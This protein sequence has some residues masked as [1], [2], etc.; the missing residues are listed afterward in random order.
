MS[1]KTMDHSCGDEKL[2]ALTCCSCN[3]DLKRIK[4]LVNKPK[5]ICKS[6]GRVANKKTNLCQPKP[7][8]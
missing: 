8:N 1:R 3:L 7:L 6:C 5:F 2:C 4:K